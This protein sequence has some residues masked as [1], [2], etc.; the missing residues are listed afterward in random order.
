MGGMASLNGM[1]C[2]RG[3]RPLNKYNIVDT[4]YSM[5]ETTYINNIKFLNY[6]YTQ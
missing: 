4:F 6:I 1:S 3:C 5:L 2:W